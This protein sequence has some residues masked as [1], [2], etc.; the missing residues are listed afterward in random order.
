MSV[1]L[2]L[3][4]GLGLGLC[5]LATGSSFFDEADHFDSTPGRGSSRVT[6]GSGDSCRGGIVG[7]GSS[8]VTGGSG[9][10]GGGVVGMGSCRVTGGS[11]NS[12]RGGAVALGNRGEEI[13]PPTRRGEMT[14]TAQAL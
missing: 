11:G 10:S 9:D 6:G 3:G 7:R 2:L 4:V 12:C 14:C 13:K 1:V 5:Y 8:R